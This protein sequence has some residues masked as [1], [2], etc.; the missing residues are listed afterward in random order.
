MAAH[1]AHIWVDYTWG[2][3]MLMH[4]DLNYTVPGLISVLA[5]LLCHIL[6]GCSHLPLVRRNLGSEYAGPNLAQ[7]AGELTAVGGWRSAQGKH[8]AFSSHLFTLPWAAMLTLGLGSPGVSSNSKRC[9]FVLLILLWLLPDLSRFSGSLQTLVSFSKHPLLNSLHCFSTLSL[10]CC[11][12]FSV[13][14]VEGTADLQL[15]KEQKLLQSAQYFSVGIIS[16]SWSV[17]FPER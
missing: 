7:G 12:P 10:S 1:I 6:F 11:L 13:F 8:C 17:T 3:F 15:W 2:A 14:P 4:V 5:F 9:P 16:G